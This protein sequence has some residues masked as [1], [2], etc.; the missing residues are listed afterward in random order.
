MFQCDCCGLCCMHIDEF[1]INDGL[2]RGDG[3]CK[4]FDENTHLCQIYENR[5]IICNVD[6]FYTSFLSSQ[7]S[8]DEF[9][10]INYESCKQIKERYGD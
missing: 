8:K 3:I 6:E 4:H 2:N 10:S 7:I 9:Y 1:I 5:P